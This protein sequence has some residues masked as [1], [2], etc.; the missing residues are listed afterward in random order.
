MVSLNLSPAEYVIIRILFLHFIRS[1]IHDV[2][3]IHFQE[4]GFCQF[5][6]PHFT[7]NL[8]Y[9]RIYRYEPDIS[10]GCLVT[11]ARKENV[12][13]RRLFFTI[14]LAS[15]FL[16]LIATELWSAEYCSNSAAQLQIHLNSAG[17]NGENDVIMVERGTYN[18]A[19]VYNP[20][21][22]NS[23]TLLGGYNAGCIDRVLDPSKTIIDS[24]G[25]DSVL[26]FYIANSSGNGHLT[27]D[28]FTIK[29]GNST[30]SGGG[31]YV[32]MT[33]D[34]SA[35]GDITLSNN[36]ILGNYANVSGGG[37]SLSSISNSGNS[38]NIILINN[39]ITGNTANQWYGGGVMVQSN[40]T[41]G[42][43]GNV[44]LINNTI[45]GNTAN[46]YGYGGGVYFAMFGGTFN[47]YNNIIWGNSAP[48]ENGKDINLS[49]I[50]TSVANGYYN[51]YSSILGSWTNS[52]DNID[53]DPLFVDPTGGDFHLLRGSNCIDA[54]TNSAPEIPN[55]DFEGNSRVIDGDKDGI[56]TVDMGADEYLVKANLLPCT[57]LLL[58]NE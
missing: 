38:G 30:G 23:I 34:S 55:N 15:A 1:T 40:S 48:W 44:S 45:T 53:E 29:N 27:V 57:S 4:S 33:S 16:S 49:Q 14:F 19:F 46:Q 22:G 25:N 13:M 31:L 6:L 32:Y 21:E 26:Y 17:L 56:A 10:I 8:N 47:V 43:P 28:G 5:L 36:I 24:G 9:V 41:S 12:T 52:G 20:S 51:D 35:S 3:L 58:F 50:E 39:I 7:E 54:G 18:G 11:R 42:T 2:R 37:A